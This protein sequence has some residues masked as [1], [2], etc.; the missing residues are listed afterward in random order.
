MDGWM[1][2]V[3]DLP[4]IPHTPHQA[5]VTEYGEM[6]GSFRLIDFEFSYQLRNRF[7]VL[8]QTTQNP[9]PRR[10]AHRL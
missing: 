9:Q 10:I 4:T 8:H 3:A 7:G 5:R 2:P 1:E 6:M